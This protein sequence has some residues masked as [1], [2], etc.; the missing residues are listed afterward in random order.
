M[1]DDN[2]VE[3][4]CKVPEPPGLLPED[5]QGYAFW[6]QIHSEYV[7]SEAQQL[8]LLYEACRI[9]NRIEHCEREMDHQEML[10]LG[11]N[12]QMI[13]NPLLSHAKELRGSLLATVK[14]LALPLEYESAAEVE[15]AAVRSARA[16]A[17]ANARWS[18][19]KGGV[20]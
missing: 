1:S 18:V 11:G 2:V 6:C 19:R 3:V 9:I 14:A 4:E 13:I 10:V 17:A 5:T 8:R 20:A 12:R 15:A 7:V 16:R